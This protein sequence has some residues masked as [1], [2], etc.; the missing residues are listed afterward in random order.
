M[1]SRAPLTLGGL[2]CPTQLLISILTVLLR[3]ASSALCHFKAPAS[4]TPPLQPRGRGACKTIFFQILFM[5]RFSFN[6]EEGVDR[7]V[8]VISLFFSFLFFSWSLP[9]CQHVF[10]RLLYIT[11]YLFMWLGTSCFSSLLLFPSI[12]SEKL[13]AGGGTVG[14]EESIFGRWDLGTTMTG[15]LMWT[16]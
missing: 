3:S 1:H 13:G 4:P 8:G 10:R 6:L 15:C 9:L 11:S 12:S 14:L 7:V 16:S 2:L 5:G